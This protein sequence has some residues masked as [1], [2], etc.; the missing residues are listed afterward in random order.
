MSGRNFVGNKRL[1]E[2]PAGQKVRSVSGFRKRQWNPSDRSSNRTA[3]TR[4]EKTLRTTTKSRR[5]ERIKTRNK[6]C[7]AS[8][9]PQTK[10]RW[11]A[12][13]GGRSLQRLA[14]GHTL[15]S[16]S[17]RGAV[18][19]KVCTTHPPLPPSSTFWCGSD[20]KNQPV[21]DDSFHGASRFPPKRPWLSAKRSKVQ[22]PETKLVSRE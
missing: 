1:S 8:L 20:P 13:W 22:I 12:G 2:K 3:R 5:V 18:V 14:P 9:V 15:S 7:F 21:M 6:K 4:A 11:A 19:R 16:G 10:R 17:G